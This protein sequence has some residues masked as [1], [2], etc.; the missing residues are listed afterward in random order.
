MNGEPTAKN[1]A[2]RKIAD[3]KLIVD[4]TL[5]SLVAWYVRPAM[6]LFSSALISA[7]RA[8]RLFNM[9]LPS[10]VLASSMF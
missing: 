8:I 1:V 5:V 4:I 3:I 9:L 7:S 2:G 10:L 6:S